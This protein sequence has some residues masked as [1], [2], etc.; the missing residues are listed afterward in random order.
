M[1]KIL[2][3]LSKLL[4]RSGTYI[5]VV[6]KQQY[7]YISQEGEQKEESARDGWSVVTHLLAFLVGR[8]NAHLV[9]GRDGRF[10]PGR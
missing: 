8:A 7:K 6:K 9:I 10:Y 1:N 5:R 3:Y 2:P 4:V